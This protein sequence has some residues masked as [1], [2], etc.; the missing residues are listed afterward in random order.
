MEWV[1]K[2]VVVQLWIGIWVRSNKDLCYRNFLFSPYSPYWQ[3][4][5]TVDSIRIFHIAPFC[6]GE[7]CGN[8]IVIIIIVV[9]SFVQGIY[10]HIP[11]TIYVPREYSVAAILLLP[12]MV[13]ISLVPS[14]E[15][16]VFLL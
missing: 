4:L 3:I 12:F 2:W 1:S 14:V 7:V 10:T 5:N 11:E 9:I 8:S 13:L 16:I 6:F 15:S